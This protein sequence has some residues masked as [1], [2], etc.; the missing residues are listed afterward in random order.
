MSNHKRKV[1]ARNLELED[2][3]DDGESE[4]V[5]APVK[6]EDSW[7]KTIGYALLIALTVR[8][9]VFEPFNIPSS[10][11]KPTLLIGDYLFVSKFSYGI[12]KYSFPFGDKIFGGLFEGRILG[13]E[14]ERGDVIV[15][16]KPT[17]PSIDFIKR[18]IGLPGDTIQV[19]G[20]QL[21]IN[22][23]VVSRD[24]VRIGDGSD[25]LGLGE[26]EYEETLP[27]GV[28]HLIWE[29]TDQAWQDNTRP[30][31]VPEG[32]YFFMGDNRDNSTDSRFDEVGV[33]PFENLIGRA[34]MLFFS[35][36]GDD[37]GED[38]GDWW[39]IWKWGEMIRFGRIF[40]GIN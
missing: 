10:S 28:K 5:T 6:E 21:H 12:S 15:F 26:K 19:I 29:R 33:V 18:L 23:T 40:N 34:D 7:I 25:G 38:Y 1:D 30:Y 20:G 13:Q 27:N 14:P 31:T 36:R 2:P 35:H 17:N 16:R 3:K 4:A 39:E 24:L 8:T 11:M 9:L 37:G 32:Y 22:G